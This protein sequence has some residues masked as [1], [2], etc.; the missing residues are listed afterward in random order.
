MAGKEQDRQDELE[1]SSKQHSLRREVASR[2][3][4]IYRQANEALQQASQLI[5][6][7]IE[8]LRQLDE[9]AGKN[10]ITQTGAEGEQFKQAEP[11]PPWRLEQ[12]PDLQ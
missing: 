4:R 12:P 11:L 1:V 8:S 9:S 7:E 6:A 5:M 2:K 3:F 10:E